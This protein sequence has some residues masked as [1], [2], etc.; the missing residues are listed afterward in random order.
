MPRLDFSKDHATDPGFAIGPVVTVKGCPFAERCR[1]AMNVC[2]KEM[3]PLTSISPTHQ[4][5]CWLE[6]LEVPP[7]DRVRGVWLTQIS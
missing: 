5:N 7:V 2:H 3:P 4:V 6:D 1:Y